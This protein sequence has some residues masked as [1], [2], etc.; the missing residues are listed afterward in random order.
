DAARELAAERGI[1]LN[2]CWIGPSGDAQDIYFDLRN[3]VGFGDSHVALVRPDGHV[4]W[5]GV[6]DGNPR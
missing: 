6:R 5:A 1:P 4:A 3:R 2:T